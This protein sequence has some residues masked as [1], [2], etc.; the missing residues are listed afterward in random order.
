[1]R[2]MALP[3]SCGGR[4]V[5]AVNGCQN[6]EVCEWGLQVAVPGITR[7]WGRPPGRRLRDST[8]QAGRAVGDGP[9]VRRPRERLAPRETESTSERLACSTE[10]GAALPRRSNPPVSRSSRSGRGAQARAAVEAPV[11]ACGSVM[12]SVQKKNTNM[13]DWRCKSCD[14]PLWN[15]DRKRG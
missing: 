11:C 14:K 6:G 8:G 1:V 4:R 12:G 2:D 15:R 5:A 3:R 13:P 9:L 10:P 7:R